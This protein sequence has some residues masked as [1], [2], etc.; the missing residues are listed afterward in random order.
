MKKMHVVIGSCVAITVAVLAWVLLSQNRVAVPPAGMPTPAQASRTAAPA[1]DPAAHVVAK[2]APEAPARP[3]RSAPPV[4]LPSDVSYGVR[5][6]AGQTEQEDYTVRAAAIHSLPTNLKR[7]D[8]EGLY[9]FLRSR[10]DA[11]PDMDALSLNALKNDTMQVLIAQDALPKDLLA[12]ML[13]LYR[14]PTMDI[15]C[16]DY[17]LQHVALYYER[18]WNP[19]DDARLADPDRAAALAVYE[20][21]LASKGSGFAG[22]AL[23]GL[24][25][26]SEQ[27]PEVDRARLGERSLA[28]ALDE[29]TEP[30]TRV[31]AVGMC[32]L[33]GKT[34]VLPR[35]R[36]LA[37]TGENTPLRL[38]SVGSLGL[39][40]EAQD[41]ELVE[42][43]GAGSDEA[44]RKAAQVALKRLRARL[45]Q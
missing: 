37:Q 5:L 9:A 8:V 35:A 21:A 24:S 30:A 14:N 40:G 13:A 43:L 3:A 44:V 36:I 12:V 42:S 1:R 41:L 22:T 26:L 19:A 25:R 33:L 45:G 10:M 29:G 17:C 15:L 2:V 34:E 4:V 27:Y 16:R 31:T 23:L 38:A 11:H 18:R 20:E 28:I 7:V 32:G 6:I 39:I